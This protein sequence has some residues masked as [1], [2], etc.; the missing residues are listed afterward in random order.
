MSLQSIFSC[1]LG[2]VTLNLKAYLFVYKIFQLFI[3]FFY[4]YS[5]QSHRLQLPSKG[6]VS[7]RIFMDTFFAA[8]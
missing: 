2:N 3:N 6:F 8:V 4:N 1:V 5:K 7:A